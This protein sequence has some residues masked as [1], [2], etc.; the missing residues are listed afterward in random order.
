[1]QQRLPESLK[2]LKKLALLLK[3]NHTKNWRKTPHAFWLAP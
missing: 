2:P 3:H 1:M